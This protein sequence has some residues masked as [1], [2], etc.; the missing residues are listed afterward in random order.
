MGTREKAITKA[1]E[2]R[3]EARKHRFCSINEYGPFKTKME[4]GTKL[5]GPGKHPRI[6]NLRKSKNCLIVTATIELSL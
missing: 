6:R 3:L 1:R 4:G 5:A 2:R